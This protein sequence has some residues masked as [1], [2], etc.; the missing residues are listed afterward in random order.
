VS[1]GRGLA[2]RLAP[3]VCKSILCSLLPA[4][5]LDSCDKTGAASLLFRIEERLQCLVQGIKIGR[6]AFYAPVIN[7][8]LTK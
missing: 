4:Y 3:I 6:L 8:S 5:L 7:E 2:R 1:L